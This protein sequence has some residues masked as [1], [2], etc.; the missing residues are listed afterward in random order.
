MEVAI[1]RPSIVMGE[2]DTGWTPAFNVLYWPLR[3]F[4]RGLFDQVPGEARR[5]RRRRARRLRRGRHL[6][7]DRVRCA[8]AR[9]TSSAARDAA[10]V[11]ELS[12][13]ACAHFGRP[14]PPYVETGELGRRGGRRAR[15]GLP[16]VLRHGGRLRRHAHARAA[17][18]PGAAAADATSTRCST[19]PTRPAGASAARRATRPARASARAGLTRRRRA[20]SARIPRVVDVLVIGAG[21]SGLVAARELGARGHEV[22]VLEARDRIGGRVWLQRGALRGPRPRHGRRLGRRRPAPRLVRGRP[23]RRRARAR[24]AARP[25]CAGASAAERVD[26]ALPVDVADL[27]EL[28]RARGRAARRRPPPRSRAAAR[29]PGARGPRRPGG[30]LDRRARAA[31]P[32]RGAAAVLGLRLRLGARR[33]TPRCS[34]SCAGSRPPA[35]GS[36]STSRRRCSAGACRRAPRRCT[37]RSPRTCAARSCSAPRS[38]RS[39]RALIEVVVTTPPASVTRRAA[40]SSRSRSACCRRSRSRRRCR[41]PSGA[42]ASATTPARASRRG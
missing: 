39:R 33:R 29:R 40:R 16:A 41:P 28:E 6:Q 24:R 26:R 1:A 19:T 8:R 30:R 7:A 13:L 22:R 9:S 37:R 34:S 12:D 2:S 5:A 23:L 31:A 42:P 15:R 18:A 4:A 10:T 14:R 11:E 36:G 21:L 35:T 32:R 25:A 38:P 17:R 20:G 3:A 27:G